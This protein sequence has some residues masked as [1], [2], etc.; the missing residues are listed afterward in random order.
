[1]PSRYAPVYRQIRKLQPDETVIGIEGDLPESIHHPELDPLVAPAT[2]RALRAR[3]IGDPPVG[4]SEHQDL[5]QLLEDDP[6]WDA[7]P[8]ASERMVGLVL[9]QEGTEL[10]PDGLDEVRFECGHG[11]YS[12]RSG[13]L[14]NSP[15]DGAS[16][17]A[18]HL[19]PL[20]IDGS[21]K[22]SSLRS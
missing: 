20:P 18:L 19:D 16:V 10:L 15:N 3:S 12:F 14:E 11:A 21:S 13:S 17:P 22:Q 6:L 5:D 8:V 2:Q 4:T 9:G 7:P 1:V